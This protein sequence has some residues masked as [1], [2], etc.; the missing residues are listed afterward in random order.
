MDIKTN[1]GIDNYKRGKRILPILLLLFASLLLLGCT[2]SSSIPGIPLTM[3]QFISRLTTLDLNSWMAGDYNGLFL[4]VD[5]NRIGVIDSNGGGGSVTVFRDIDGGFA[6][7]VYL[8]DQK[9]DGGDAS[10]E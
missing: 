5:G 8:N 10:G 3:G 1:L 9:I 2:E 6:N 4:Y 7:S